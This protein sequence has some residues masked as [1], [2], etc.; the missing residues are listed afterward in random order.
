VAKV[1]GKTDA[2][3]RSIAAALQ[4]LEANVPN[5][6]ADV[7]RYNSASAR[8]RIVAPIFANLD[9]AERHELAWKYLERLD[10]E[11]LAELSILLP[12]TPEEHASGRSLMNIE[13]DH[14][15]PSGL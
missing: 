11:V 10:E 15:S 13:F 9:K 4:Q 1:L 6:R 14:P 8:V 3:V 7:Y 12:L 2:V 5:A